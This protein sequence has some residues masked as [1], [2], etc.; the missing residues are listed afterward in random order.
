[1][2]A[3]TLLR[4]HILYHMDRRSWYW[5]DRPWPIPCKR[6]FVVWLCRFANKYQVAYSKP[7]AYEFR[8]CVF[9]GYGSF[10]SLCDSNSTPSCLMCSA[11]CTLS[12]LMIRSLLAPCRLCG[13][14]TGTS[15]GMT[16][17]RVHYWH[18]LVINCSGKRVIP[19]GF[20]P[21]LL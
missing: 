4:S 19:S 20:S 16:Y 14:A 6:K 10:M 15:L 7:W 17:I 3:F 11:F 1:M 9:T 13:T 5:Y 2:S 21:S 8:L 12:M 18:T